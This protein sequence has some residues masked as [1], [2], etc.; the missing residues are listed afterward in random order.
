M[1]MMITYVFFQVDMLEMWCWLFT[2]MV[3]TILFFEILVKHMVV[4]S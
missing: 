4:E 2:F 1:V 3:I